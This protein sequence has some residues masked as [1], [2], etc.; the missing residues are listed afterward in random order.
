LEV[1]SI[2][3]FRIT[4]LLFLSNQECEESFVVTLF[5]I[6]LEEKRKKSIWI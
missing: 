4:Y 1:H 3:I 6:Q 5:L 2:F